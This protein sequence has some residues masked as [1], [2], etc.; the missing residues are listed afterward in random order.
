MILWGV[1]RYVDKKN[2]KKLACLYFLP[3]PCS[4]SAGH[5]KIFITR[6]Y[7]SYIIYREFK[8]IVDVTISGGFNHFE[9]GV[10]IICPHS[11]ANKSGFQPPETLHWV[12]IIKMIM[13]I[14]SLIKEGNSFRIV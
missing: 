12:I 1:S 6:T 9:K 2:Q 3:L 4:G 14:N 7:I 11:N 10:Q 5:I 13:I 8:N